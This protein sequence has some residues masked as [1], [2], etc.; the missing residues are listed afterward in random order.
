M[1]VAV[2]PESVVRLASKR[3]LVYPKMGDKPRCIPEWYS[4]L[5]LASAIS[6]LAANGLLVVLVLFRTP[7]ELKVYRRV[8]L[9]NVSADLL[10]TICSYVIEVV[11]RYK[12]ARK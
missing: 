9:G 7:R 11:R 6:S 4:S 8:I 12:I 3:R 2:Q 1:S 5:E 10:F